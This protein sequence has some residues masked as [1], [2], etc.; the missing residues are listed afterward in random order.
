MTLTHLISSQVA[1]PVIASGGAGRPEHLAEV[2]THGLADAALIASMV[3]YDAYTI[4]EIKQFLHNQ[5][6]K[7]RMVW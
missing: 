4:R 7:V 3:H 1:I 2:L 5:G 6:I